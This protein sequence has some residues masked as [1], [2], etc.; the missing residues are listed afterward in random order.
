MKKN[1][2]TNKATKLDWI[3][4]AFA[5]ANVK[6]Y[7]DTCT[8]FNLYVKSA[9][10]NVAI[11]GAK[12]ISSEGHDDFIAWPSRADANDKSKFYNECSIK[13]DDDFEKLIISEVAKMI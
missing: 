9:V 12:V 1:N 7:S 4:D 10:G 13:F 11:Y 5:I 3:N 8:F 6:N 2:T